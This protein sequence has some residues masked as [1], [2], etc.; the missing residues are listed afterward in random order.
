MTDKIMC[1]IYFEERDS[2]AAYLRNFPESILSKK[3]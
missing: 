2:V 1:K 3:I